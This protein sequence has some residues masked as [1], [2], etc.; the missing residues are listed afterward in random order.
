MAVTVPL[1]IVLIA[2]HFR[3]RIQDP[4]HCRACFQIPHL[5]DAVLPPFYTHHKRSRAPPLMTRH[6]FPA[7]LFHVRALLCG[8]LPPSLLEESR[9]SSRVNQTSPSS[10]A[11]NKLLGHF[12]TSLLWSS[13]LPVEC[14][15]SYWLM[16]SSFQIKYTPLVV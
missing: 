16:R 14:D 5:T 10:L 2:I 9:Y 6:V 13:S 4:A 8:L 12:H 15:Y 3:A 7:W 1:W 11:I